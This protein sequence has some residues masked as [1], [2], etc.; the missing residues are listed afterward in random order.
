[1]T[2]ET[3]RDAAAIAAFLDREWGKSYPRDTAFGMGSA[4]D[5]FVAVLK[6]EAF[7]TAPLQKEFRDIG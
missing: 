2:P 1:M 7:W 5:R 3:R 4:A 6:D